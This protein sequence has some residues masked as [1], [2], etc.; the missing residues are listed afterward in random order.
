MDRINRSP[1]PYYTFC[2]GQYVVVGHAA[3]LSGKYTVVLH[4]EKIIRFCLVREAKKPSFVRL[5][6][7]NNEEVKTHTKM[8]CEVITYCVVQQCVF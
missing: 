5:D 1:W 3:S 4:C 7:R 2:L 8:L 6:Q